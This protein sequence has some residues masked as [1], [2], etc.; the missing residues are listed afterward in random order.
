[1][2]WKTRRKII[3]DV[4]GCKTATRHLSDEP[5]TVEDWVRVNAIRQAYIAGVRQVV[6]DARLRKAK[7]VFGND[8]ANEPARGGM[9][10]EAD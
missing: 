10:V 6:C 7:E 9:E 1:M 8:Y 3:A 2:N 5:L 4:Y